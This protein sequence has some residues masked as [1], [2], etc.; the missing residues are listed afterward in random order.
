M[1]P[2]GVHGGELIY[3]HSFYFRSELCF[4][5]CNDICMCVVNKQFELLEFVINSIYVNL[6]Y[7]EIFLTFTDVVVWCV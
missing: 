7:N 3:F 6:K 4:L 1:Q 5:N 2:I